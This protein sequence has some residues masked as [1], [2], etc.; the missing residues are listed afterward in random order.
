MM[1]GLPEIQDS[2]LGGDNR[3]E[4]GQD[5]NGSGV[6][7]VDTDCPKDGFDK[8][9]N[10]NLFR[11]RRKKREMKVK[12][13]PTYYLVSIDSKRGIYFVLFSKRKFT[14]EHCK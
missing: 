11:E 5:S 12:Q 14:Y 6:G 1:A 8:R 4:Q 10:P 3:N 9:G 2:I 7:R 13:L